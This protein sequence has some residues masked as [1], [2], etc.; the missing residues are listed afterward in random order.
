VSGTV[1]VMSTVVVGS[2]GS[3]VRTLVWSAV[4]KLGAALLLAVCAGAVVLAN[5]AA[6]F[7]GDRWSVGVVAAAVVV[8]AVACGGMSRWRVDVL[9]ASAGLRAERQVGAVLESCGATAV[10]HSVQ[11]GAGGDVDH[12]VLGPVVVAVET[13]A[14]SGKVSYRDDR[15]TVGRKVLRGNP[16]RQARRQAVA[17]RGRVGVRVDAVVC[18]VGMSN[19]PFVVEGVHVCSVDDLVSLLGSLRPCVDVETA[20]GWAFE[21]AGDMPVRE[22]R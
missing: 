10:L 1:V 2:P 7:E 9:K 22:R 16:V 14:G 4:G 15:V 19:S 12:I 5:V 21:L 13:K 18:V 17:L 3:H 8:V 6:V 11:L 20:R